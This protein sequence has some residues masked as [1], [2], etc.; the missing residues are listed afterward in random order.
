MKKVTEK[1]KELQQPAPIGLNPE[2]QSLDFSLGLALFKDSKVPFLVKLKSMFF[3]AIVTA[4][5]GEI[6][7]VISYVLKL[8]HDHIHSTMHWIFYVAGFVLFSVLSII[9]QSSHSDAT[10]LRYE[11]LG[12]IPIKG[13]NSSDSDS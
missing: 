2:K 13:S 11:R 8:S 1:L 7:H 3:G 5:L 12:V 10:R 6:E 9:W 4:G